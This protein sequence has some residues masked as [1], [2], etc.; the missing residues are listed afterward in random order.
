MLLGF[1]ELNQNELSIYPN[2]SNGV[3]FVDLPFGAEEVQ[4]LSL[5]GQLIERFIPIGESTMQIKLPQL[6]GF[7]LLRVKTNTA[8]LTEKISIRNN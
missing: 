3:F 1:S 6:N 2:P 4:V 7:Y 8:I 5:N